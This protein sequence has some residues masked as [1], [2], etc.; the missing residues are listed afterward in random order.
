MQ[1]WAGWALGLHATSGIT[2]RKP[3][4]QG[5]SFPA[6]GG[7]NVQKPTERVN[8]FPLCPVAEIPLKNRGMADCR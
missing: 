6:K 1:P 3:D 2:G 8:H 7:G 4:G 5:S